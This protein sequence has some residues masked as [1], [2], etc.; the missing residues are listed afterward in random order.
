MAFLERDLGSTESEGAWPAFADLLAAC[1]M[2]FLVLFAVVA[3]PALRGVAE[4]LKIKRTLGRIENDL[5]HSQRGAG[6]EVQA[7]GDHVLIR[8][9]GDATFTVDRS[10]IEDLRPE[11]RETLRTIADLLKRDS[12]LR[13][14]DQVQ[15]AGHTSAEGSD[16]RNW[17]LSSERATTVALFFIDSLGI[18][19]CQIT[20]LGRG[21]YY[22]SSPALAMTSR[23]P[24]PADRRIELEIRP[25]IENDSAQAQRR[26]QC[27]EHRPA[28]Q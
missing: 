25:V 16:S 22:P 5:R 17:A 2:L 21:R 9:R 28:V 27:V 10:A 26:R 11:G 3:V 14:I 13:V 20:A 19:A 8:I 6:Y 24:N 4:G 23:R 7:F 12:L 1:T 15:V 18:G